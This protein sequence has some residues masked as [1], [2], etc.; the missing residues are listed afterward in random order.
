[1]SWLIEAEN[2]HT[3]PIVSDP[4][5]LWGDTR[6]VIVA[7]SD[8]SSSALTHIFYHLAKDPLIISKLRSELE[9]IYKPGSETEL[10]DIQEA[11]YLNGVINEALR[12]HP[13]VPSGLLRQT[14]PEGIMVG[15]IFIPGSV[16]V[17]APT[18]S[19]GRCKCRWTRM[20]FNLL[21]CGS[22]V[23]L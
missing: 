5:W 15:E 13:P 20:Y 6:L 7:G 2:E 22:G 17:S 4:R 9:P 16:T 23:M 14:P 11:K 19:M 10:R 1:M 12:M 8:T 21:T 3:D 18:W